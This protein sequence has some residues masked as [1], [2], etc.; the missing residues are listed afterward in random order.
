MKVDLIFLANTSNEGVYQ[1]NLDCINSCLDAKQDSDDYTL[2]IYLIES[3][4]SA[5]YAYP[6]MVT[7]IKPCLPFNFHQFLNIGIQH[8]SSDWVALC[9][10]DLLFKPGWL[11][12]IFAVADKYPNFFSFCP[13]DYNYESTPLCLFPKHVEKFDGYTINQHIAGWCIVFKRKILHCIGMLDERFDFYFSDN[14]YAMTLQKYAI[15]HALVT[16]S[17]VSH[18]GKRST[19]TAPGL[20]IPA[21]WRIF[22]LTH[23]RLKKNQ[24]ISSNKKMLTGYYIFH[25]KWGSTCSIKIRQFLL[26]HLKYPWLAKILFSNL[27]NLICSLDVRLSFFFI[28][29]FVYSPK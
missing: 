5:D 10:N 14:D 23:L 1:M 26:H 8:S 27:V 28:K 18:L 11:T 7:V 25:T 16:G 22:F 3:N 17:E 29:K 4:A 2:L 6:E 24:W 13:I 20:I 19:T 9:N 12:E 15:Q 21:F